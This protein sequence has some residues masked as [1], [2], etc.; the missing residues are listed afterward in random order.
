VPTSQ[1]TKAAGNTFYAQAQYAG[2]DNAQMLRLPHLADQYSLDLMNHTTSMAYKNQ[3][4]QAQT[5]TSYASPPYPHASGAFGFTG[6]ARSFPHPIIAS[7][8]EKSQQESQQ[9]LSK[10][11][12]L[13]A[14][15]S[16]YPNPY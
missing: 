6:T 3:M 2:A 11:T 1:T 7:D 12:V 9:E 8:T 5:L 10:Q 13:Q 15:N 16:L 4:N 14:A